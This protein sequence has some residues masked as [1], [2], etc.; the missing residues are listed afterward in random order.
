[1]TAN[2]THDQTDQLRKSVEKLPGLKVAGE[3]AG[4]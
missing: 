4:K 2:Y 3:E 1:M